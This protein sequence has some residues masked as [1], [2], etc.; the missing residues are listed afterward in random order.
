MTE[1]IVV[2]PRILTGKPIIR[3]TR[4][5]IYL[6]LNLL[7]RGRKVQDIIAE[8][9]ELSKEDVVATLTYAATVAQY[10]TKQLETSR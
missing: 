4:I 8:Y 3:G 9:P 1:R 6:I 10:E 2:N 7:A 5:P